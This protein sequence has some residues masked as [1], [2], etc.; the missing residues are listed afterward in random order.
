MAELE[1]VEEDDTNITAKHHRSVDLQGYELLL[2]VKLKTDINFWFEWINKYDLL[3]ERSGMSLPADV[4]LCLWFLAVAFDFKRDRLLN[5]IK[6]Q[7]E[8]S[9]KNTF[10]FHRI[11][12]NLLINYLNAHQF[13][14]L[15]LDGIAK[16]REE[17]TVPTE[18]FR[19]T[20]IE[21]LS[22]RFN[23][24]HVIPPDIGRLTKLQYLALTNNKLQNKSI[25]YTLTFC[26]QLK[27]LLLDYNLLDALPGFLQQITSLE[28]VYR[29]G[30][31]NYFKSTFMW[32]HTDVN[33]RVLN[34]TGSDFPLKVPNTLQFLAAKSVITS[35]WNFFCN[36]D[37]PSLLKDYLSDIYALFNIC[38]NCNSATFFNQPGYR[39]ITFRNPYLGNT[40]VPFQ[41]WACSMDCATAIELPARER[42]MATA[43]ELDSRYAEYVHECH[44]LSLR[45]KKRYRRLPTR[46]RGLISE[47]TPGIL[48][49]EDIALHQ[50]QSNCCIVM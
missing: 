3:K 4:S 11:R 46:D 28:T 32:Y 25:P 50:R 20:S 1:K 5:F 13:T 9:K 38:E 30:N 27:T 34:V 31:H 14:E 41:H 18:I 45:M 17:C 44:R 21:R 43:H 24:L 23:C 10:A 15:H 2:L 7:V 8:E 42:Q 6:E 37:V 19:C 33:E 40:C 12:E 39:V 16:Y 29:H 26:T 22:L 35:K 49:A 47:P 48:S 36:D